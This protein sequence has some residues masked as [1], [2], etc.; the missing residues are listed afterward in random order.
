M[1]GNEKKWKRG[2]LTVAVGSLLM[3][4]AGWDSFLYNPKYIH[5]ISPQTTYPFSPWLPHFTEVHKKTY[6]QLA[7][8]ARAFRQFQTYEERDPTSLQ[9]VLQSVYFPLNSL[10]NYFQNREMKVYEDK[11]P[12]YSES[13][14]GDLFYLKS[15]DIKN[16][17]PLEL[18]VYIP[19]LPDMPLYMVKKLTRY[20]ASPDWETMEARKDLRENVFKKLSP[21]DQ[22][23]YCYSEYL[24]TAA[25]ILTDSVIEGIKLN[26]GGVASLSDLSSAWWLITTEIPNPYTGKAIRQ[27]PLDKP[28]PGDISIVVARF[29]YGDE[30][31]FV[32]GWGEGGK[33]VNP[34]LLQALQRMMEEDI[35]RDGYY[36]SQNK[37]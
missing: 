2:F 15:Q 28:S 3:V 5:R 17:N 7:I 6:A 4:S 11:E 31:V 10:K 13:L 8:L 26:P 9:E 34:R 20:K 37:R 14:V 27:V 25:N 24:S 19:T 21:I 12:V 1:K 16:P 36:L 30:D 22:K 18:R 32:V 35:A 33:S 29:D 23:V